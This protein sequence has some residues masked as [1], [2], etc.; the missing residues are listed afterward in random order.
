MKTMRILTLLALILIAFVS[1]AVHY[2]YYTQEDYTPYSG[3][4]EVSVTVDTIPSDTL[5]YMFKVEDVRLPVKGVDIYD[6][7]YHKVSTEGIRDG[8]TIVGFS[9]WCMYDVT[10]GRKAPLLLYN[11][12]FEQCD[13]IKQ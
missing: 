9:L 3:W 8:Y 6:S 11:Y 7:V 13:S 5:V 1:I 10:L 2:Y 4:V 12:T